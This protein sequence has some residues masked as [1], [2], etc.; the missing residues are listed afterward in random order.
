MGISEERIEELKE[1]YKKEGK[2]IS[3][4]EAREAARKLVGLFEI[5]WEMSKKEVDRQHRLKKEPGGFPVD[6]SYSCLVCG[7]G[8]NETTGWYDWYGQT[9]LLCR[10]AIRS[11]AVPAFICKE[12]DSYYA[13]WAIKSKFNLKHH[14][15]KKHIAAGT[16]KPRMIMK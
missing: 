11:G 12:R 1:I 6:G 14:A 10:D 15:L 13:T 4:E 2:E 9:C 7:N 16:H 8:I 5:I 3:D